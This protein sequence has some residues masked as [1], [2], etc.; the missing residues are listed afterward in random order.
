[1]ASISLVIFKEPDR[2]MNI[3]SKY[4]HYINLMMFV[5]SISVVGAWNV[6]LLVICSTR[7]IVTSTEEV[8]FSPLSICLV[9]SLCCKHDYTKTTEFSERM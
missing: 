3:W 2:V 9:V 5:G 7:D 8:V 6:L 1:M 4:A